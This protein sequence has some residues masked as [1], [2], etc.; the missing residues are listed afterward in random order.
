MF[1]TLKLHFFESKTA[2][3]RISLPKHNY[4]NCN[5]DLPLL[6]RTCVACVRP[7]PV[8]RAFCLGHCGRLGQRWRQ[9]LARRER[10]AG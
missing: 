7:I 6:D 8:A 10:H 3:S 5:F 1:G 4:E 2:P 9:Y